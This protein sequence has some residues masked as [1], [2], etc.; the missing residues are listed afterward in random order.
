MRAL[1]TALSTAGTVQSGYTTMTDPMVDVY[2]VEIV[3]HATGKVERRMGPMSERK[4]DKVDTGA[5][6]N[7]DHERYFT[8]IVETFC[9]LPPVTDL[10]VNTGLAT[11]FAVATPHRWF[12]LASYGAEPGRDVYYC[13]TV[14]RRI[15]AF[16]QHGRLY[17]S[18]RSIGGVKTCWGCRK[19]VPRA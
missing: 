10:T 2:F 15:A 5:N 7:L 19:P 17:R 8:R 3:E 6:I 4:A 18:A 1:S 12:F 13:P 14:T 16:F 9:G 11:V